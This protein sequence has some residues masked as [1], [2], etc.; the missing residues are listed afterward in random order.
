MKI[1]IY[2]FNENAVASKYGIG[3]FILNLKRCFQD[4][5][6]N[7]TILSLNSDSK[8]VEIRI[9]GNVC[10]VDIPKLK[11]PSSKRIDVYYK[12]SL[13]ILRHYFFKEH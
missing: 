3:T 6:Y 5:I 4:S 2:I 9:D 13:F 7:L 12:N 8:E 1:N 11:Y 10:L